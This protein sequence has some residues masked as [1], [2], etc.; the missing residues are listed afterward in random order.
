LGYGRI[1]NTSVIAF[2][3]RDLQEA[4]FGQGWGGGL[5]VWALDGLAGVKDRKKCAVLEDLEKAL[6]G[7][8]AVCDLM[9]VAGSVCVLRWRHGVRGN[10]SRKRRAEKSF[11]K[12]PGQNAGCIVFST[13]YMSQKPWDKPGTNVGQAGTTG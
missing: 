5:K 11:L 9:I 7:W 3:G 4:D 6:F 8:A 2:A 10:G 12:N 13:V 1:Q